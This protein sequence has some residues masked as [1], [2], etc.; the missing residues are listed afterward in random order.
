MWE[1]VKGMTNLNTDNRELYVCKEF[2]RPNELKLF[3]KRFGT[4]EGGDVLGPVCN[5]HRDRIVIDTPAIVK[6]FKALHTRK[7]SG[8]DG[9]SPFILHEF[10]DEL[11][12]TWFPLFQLS[13]DTHIIPTQWKR[14]VIIPIRYHANNDYRP[15]TTT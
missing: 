2:E 15:I 10:A 7:A 12:P 9:I 6:V 14:A 5:A 1:R 3:Y 13:V 8:P 4:G 11:A